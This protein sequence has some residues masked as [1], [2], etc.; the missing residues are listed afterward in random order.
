MLE[1]KKLKKKPKG[2]AKKKFIRKKVCKF[3]PEEIRTID[4]KDISRLRYFVTERGKIVPS[5]ISGA[6]AASQRY[7]VRQIKRARHIA[8]LPYV[9]ND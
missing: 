9:A 4:F 6:D 5:R 8:L 7:L 2:A 3:T 1:K